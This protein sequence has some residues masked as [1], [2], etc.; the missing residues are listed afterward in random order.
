MNDMHC[1]ST[2]L[3]IVCTNIF[4]LL[5]FCF[6]FINY[7]LFI[8]NCLVLHPVILQLGNSARHLDLKL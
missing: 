5:L 3:L 7:C 8:I 1:L 6:E 4:G 2:L